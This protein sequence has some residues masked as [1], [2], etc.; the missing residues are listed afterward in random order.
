M[1]CS[2]RD[3]DWRTG[4]IKKFITCKD[5]E[6]YKYENGSRALF[7]SEKMIRFFFAAALVAFVCA[8]N[9]YQPSLKGWVSFK[10]FNFCQINCPID[11]SIF[12]GKLYF[13]HIHFDTEASSVS[14]IIYWYSI[15]GYW[16]GIFN[17]KFIDMLCLK[18][19]N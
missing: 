5:K 17:L 12:F 10:F 6:I 15:L 4:L 14:K 19:F 13:F 8:N 18:F 11:P 16:K 2:R 7:C 3:I 9:V 1:Y